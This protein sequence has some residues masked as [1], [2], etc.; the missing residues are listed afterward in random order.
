MRVCGTSG[1]VVRSRDGARPAV[2]AG[3]GT[4]RL[5]VVERRTTSLELHAPP[6][7]SDHT[8]VAAQCR[9]EGDLEF[10]GRT[11]ERIASLDRE[12]TQIVLAMMVLEPRF[13]TERVRARSSTVRALMDHAAGLQSSRSRLVLINGGRWLSVREQ[14]T[15][16]SW[17]GAL[18][19]Q[20]RA[21]SLPIRV[22]LEARGPLAALSRRQIEI[23]DGRWLFARSRRVPTA[24]ASAPR[25]VVELAAQH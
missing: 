2:K 12:G 1:A 8:I 9:D 19:R 17:V 3:A 20:P 23:P 11:I 4:V 25:A 5:V 22:R 15:L 6:D 7:G 10:A 24:I 18:M 16:F 13:D 21:S 14:Q